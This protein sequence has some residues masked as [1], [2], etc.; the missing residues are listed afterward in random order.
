MIAV[1]TWLSVTRMLTR[2]EATAA[3]TA[4]LL[5]QPLATPIRCG[6]RRRSSRPIEI[7]RSSRPGAEHLARGHS[8]HRT[9]RRPRRPGGAGRRAGRRRSRRRSAAGRWSARSATRL[10]ARRCRAAANMSNVARRSSCASSTS[11]WAKSTT[12]GANS[13]FGSVP[14]RRARSMASVI[15]DTSAALL[16]RPPISWTTSALPE[17]RAGSDC[18]EALDRLAERDADDRAVQRL[19]LQVPARRRRPTRDCSSDSPTSS[20]ST[21]MT[22]FRPS[23]SSSCTSRLGMPALRL[24]DVHADVARLEGGAQQPGDLEPA[25]PQVG[26]DLLV[27][28]VPPVGLVADLQHHPLAV[29]PDPPAMARPSGAHVSKRA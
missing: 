22:A 27:G 3:R 18:D 17:R 20:P 2:P 13:R 10:R 4:R 29:E 16:P 5:R 11:R 26:G 6:V 14:N 7:V 19:F 9:A 8:A 23:R 15:E 24:E 28:Q 1:A 12:A 21:M 25:D